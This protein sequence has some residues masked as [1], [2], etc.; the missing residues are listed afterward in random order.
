[1]NT[2]LSR[3]LKLPHLWLFQ[4]GRFIGVPA[5]FGSGSPDNFYADHFQCERKEKERSHTR[6][7]LPA[8]LRGASA[9][10]GVRT[11]ALNENSDPTGSEFGQGSTP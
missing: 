2:C 5:R 4:V 7:V 10:R 1:M 11:T 9:L 8:S 3:G 6:L